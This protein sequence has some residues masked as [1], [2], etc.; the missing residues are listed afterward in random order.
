M[1]LTEAEELELLELEE[2]EGK[3]AAGRSI[4]APGA[5]GMPPPPANADNGI[6]G[7]WEA[8]ARAAAEGYTG[9]L[10]GR[11]AGLYG[12][13]EELGRRAGEYTYPEGVPDRPNVPLGLAFDEARQVAEARRWSGDQEHPSTVA[14]EVA[15]SFLNPVGAILGKASPVFRALPAGLQNALQVPRRG[16]ESGLKSAVTL[17]DQVV[18]PGAVQGALSAYGKGELKDIPTGLVFGGTTGLALAG[19]AKAGGFAIDLAR[20]GVGRLFPELSQAVA[21]WVR[22]VAI[23]RFKKGAGAIQSD[24]A[25]YGPD[26]ERENK[27][28]G[29]LLDANVAR[30]GDT[31]KTLLPKFER[32]ANEAGEKQGQLE[33]AVDDTA[34]A[35]AGLPSGDLESVRAE[36]LKRR[37]AAKEASQ[38]SLLTQQVRLKMA[39]DAHQRQLEGELQQLEQAHAATVRQ[40][41]ESLAAAE[42]SGKQYSGQL[43]AEQAALRQQLE[44][45]EAAAAQRDAALK[46]VA[47]QQQKALAQSL[48]GKAPTSEE[49]RQISAL[50]EKERKAAL[51]QLAKQMADLEVPPTAT[52]GIQPEVLQ[53]MGRNKREQAAALPRLAEARVPKPPGLDAELEAASKLPQDKR[54]AVLADIARRRLSQSTSEPGMPAPDPDLLPLVGQ[55]FTTKQ[56]GMERI[57]R[58]RTMFP[59]PKAPPP[60]IDDVLVGGA[61]VGADPVIAQLEQKLAQF[62]AA[63]NAGGVRAMEEAIA[64]RGGRPKEA[65]GLDVKPVVERLKSMLPRYDSY[66]DSANQKYLAGTIQDLEEQGFEGMT[67]SRLREMKTAITDNIVYGKDP[68]RA[69]DLK[70]QVASIFD[71]LVEAEFL[72]Q[73]NQAGLDEYRKTKDA[74]GAAA[75]GVKWAG[76]GQRRAVGNRIVSATDHGAGLIASNVAGDDSSGATKALLAAAGVVGNNILRKQ[77]MTAAVHLDSLS[78]YL[79]AG[80]EAGPATSAM[81]NEYGWFLRDMSRATPASAAIGYYLMHARNPKFREM[82][83]EAQK[84]LA[85]QRP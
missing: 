71:E 27:L 22:K 78:K 85:T 73:R 7:F 68:S 24:L 28:V 81:F 18:V 76:R 16:V 12:A 35:K 69:E 8:H 66:S 59:E 6:P 65:V 29:Q 43:E 5:D 44:S 51:A 21:D 57:T 26:V 49:L 46:E 38:D 15:T 10:S 64:K 33:R 42:A 23:N 75:L 63:G 60:P 52:E 70:R 4:P 2:E 25:V 56:A 39:F 30:P 50:P 14:T 84:E 45:I 47:A 13:A 62:K 83:E 40:L 72:K 58:Q 3:Q 61:G 11:I 36:R 74:F 20:N 19:G 34:A 1:G 67:A 77:S 55:D 41:E 53:L 80:A 79:R 54:A 32:M 9:G 82:D 37:T 48:K 17:A 31:P